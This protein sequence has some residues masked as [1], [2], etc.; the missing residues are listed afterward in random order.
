MQL[1]IRSLRSLRLIPSDLIDENEKPDSLREFLNE[2]GGTSGSISGSIDG[3]VTAVVRYIPL[4][5]R[6]SNNPLNNVISMLA[7]TG[8]GIIVN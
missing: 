3:T 4:R 8:S 2:S 6:V 1:S 7:E 5:L